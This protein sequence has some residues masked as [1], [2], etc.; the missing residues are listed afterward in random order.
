MR[1]PYFLIVGVYPNLMLSIV[2]AAD[3]PV[4]THLGSGAYTEVKEGLDEKDV[5]VLRAQSGDAA[6]QKAPGT[7]GKSPVR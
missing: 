2:N 6:G 5:V 3:C 7:G 4:K 1:E